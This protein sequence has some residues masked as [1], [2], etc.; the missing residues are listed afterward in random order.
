MR[1]NVPIRTCT[2]CGK[3]DQQDRLV[4]ITKSS[5][6]ALAVDL[7]RSQP[8]RG[9]WIHPSAECYRN[10]RRTGRLS[11]SLRAGGESWKQLEDFF[12]AQE[13]GITLTA[14]KAGWKLM[15]TR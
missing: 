10:A 11:R 3:R 14:T 6:S 1:N 4:R 15:G 8:G 7:D 13:E 9:A 2:G 5:G 12:T